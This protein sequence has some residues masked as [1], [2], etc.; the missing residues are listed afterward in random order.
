VLWI[1]S[2]VALD[3]DEAAA[4]INVHERTRFALLM[5]GTQAAEAAC[6]LSQAYF[7]RCES[8]FFSG[9]LPTLPRA[10]ESSQPVK[11]KVQHFCA[12]VARLWCAEAAAVGIQRSRA[13]A[14]GL[15]LYKR[16]QE[17]AR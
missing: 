5:N 16:L 12:T 9:I 3:C 15:K 10:E 6:K 7:P 14:L 17:R 2:E 1:N 13:T 4:V 11:R 8:F